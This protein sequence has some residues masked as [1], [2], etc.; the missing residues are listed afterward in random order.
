MQAL[1]ATLLPVTVGTA[2]V[3]ALRHEPEFMVQ[4]PL[5]LVFIRGLKAAWMSIS[6]LEHKPK[7]NTLAEPGV[8]ANLELGRDQRGDRRDIEERGSQS[9]PAVA[10]ITKGGPLASRGKGV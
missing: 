3:Q 4:S 2:I 1:S 5:T 9:R 7:G 8:P 6:R 10:I